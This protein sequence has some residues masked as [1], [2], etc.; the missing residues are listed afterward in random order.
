MIKGAF[1]F[2]QLANK[3]KKKMS[4]SLVHPGVEIDSMTSSREI[5]EVNGEIGR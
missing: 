5:R 4:V 3:T 1:A 2:T